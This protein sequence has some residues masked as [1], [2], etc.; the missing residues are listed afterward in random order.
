MEGLLCGEYWNFNSVIDALRHRGSLRLLSNILWTQREPTCPSSFPNTPNTEWKCSIRQRQRP[1]GWR[2]IED[3][4]DGAGLAGS[5]VTLLRTTIAGMTKALRAVI[6]TSLRGVA[7]ASIAASSSFVTVAVV[8]GFAGPA[9]TLTAITIAIVVIVVPGIPPIAHTL[10]RLGSGTSEMFSDV[11]SENLETFTYLPTKAASL[12]EVVVTAVAV[13]IT[14]LIHL[15]AW[16]WVFLASKVWR[17]HVSTIK[18][19]VA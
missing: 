1:F 6:I 3:L 9:G 4:E 11:S 10:R 16:A 5:T 8:F 12:C 14:L 17:K 13:E 19:L 7:C 18:A 15:L 2:R